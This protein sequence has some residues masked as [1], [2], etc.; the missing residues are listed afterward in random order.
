MFV[1]VGVSAGTGAVWRWANSSA[2]GLLFIAAGLLSSQQKR[3]TEEEEEEEE[4]VQMWSKM[5]GR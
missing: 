4:G 3:Q 5:G 2:L 1:S